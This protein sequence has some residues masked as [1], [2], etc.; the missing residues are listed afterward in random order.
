MRTPIKVAIQGDRASFHEIA[1]RQYYGKSV[2]LIYCQSFERVF[3]LLAKND[4]DKAFF[5]VSNSSHGPIEQV[6]SLM[7]GCDLTV[8]GEYLLLIHQ[9]LI[10]TVDSQL[11]DVKTVLSHPIALSQC[12]VYIKNQLAQASVR[13]YYDTSA[14][15]RYVKQRGDR[16]IVAIGSEEAA[17]LYGL[18]I[19]QRSIQNDPNNTTLFKSLVN[20]TS[21]SELP[22]MLVS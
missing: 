16:S 14:A 9:Y 7:S 18:K 19:L 11:K 5:A 8:E 6:H 17:T 15:I 12:S 13:D 21:H 3:D 22:A 20:P 4:V 10:G 2:E 1:A